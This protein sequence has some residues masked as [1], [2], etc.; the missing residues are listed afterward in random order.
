[1]VFDYLE[2]DTLTSISC[3]QYR[4]ILEAA[5]LLG[6]NLR[7][8]FTWWLDITLGCSNLIAIILTQEQG[9]E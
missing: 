3:L 2:S 7:I 6:I 9:K 4:N 1:M 8:R 5:V